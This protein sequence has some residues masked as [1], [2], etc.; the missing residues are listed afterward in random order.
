MKYSWTARRNAF[1]AR[2]FDEGFGATNVFQRAVRGEGGQCPEMSGFVRMPKHVDLDKSLKVVS[3]R[4]F[5][6]APSARIG[7]SLVIV[8]DSFEGGV[9]SVS[10]PVFSGL[11]GATA[12]PAS[13]WMIEN[14]RV[15]RGLSYSRQ[16]CNAFACLSL[17][18][19][20]S[21]F[22]GFGALTVS[23]PLPPIPPISPGRVSGNFRSGGSSQSGV[24]GSTVLNCNV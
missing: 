19:E 17:C 5:S 21:V 1:T 13:P 11:R 9:L 3:L 18:I 4:F 24:S 14:E 12:S 16:R 22:S 23:H 10:F 7:A 15:L 8:N 6:S 2:R 20:F